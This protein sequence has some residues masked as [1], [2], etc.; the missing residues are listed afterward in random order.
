LKAWKLG[1]NLHAADIAPLMEAFKQAERDPRRPL[2][3]LRGRLMCQRKVEDYLKRSTKVKKLAPAKRNAKSVHPTPGDITFHYPDENE[4]STP[5]NS[6]KLQTAP[7]TVS[8]QSLATTYSGSSLQST[9]L[10][11][12]ASCNGTP[13]ERRSFM[14]FQGQIDPP[15]DNLQECCDR[16]DV[17]CRTEPR[18]SHPPQSYPPTEPLHLLEGSEASKMWSAINTNK[19]FNHVVNQLLGAES[20]AGSG[21]SELKM[22]NVI[23]GSPPAPPRLGSL[24][25]LLHDLGVLSATAEHTNNDYGEMDPPQ[26]FLSH[27]F[28]GCILQRRGFRGGAEELFRLA[29]HFLDGMI[30]NSH[31]ECLVALNVMLAVLET[32]G[33]KDDAADFLSGVLV[34]CRQNLSNNPVAQTV[35]FMVA[36]ATRDLDI[37][38][39]DI[40]RLESIYERLKAQFGDTSSSALAGLYHIAWR[41][42]KEETLHERALRTLEELLPLARRTLNPSHFLIITCMTTMAGVLFRVH[43]QPESIECMWQAIQE[44][45]KKHAP[46]HPY[47]LEALHRLGTFLLGAQRFQ[48]AESTLKFVVDERIRV[49]GEGNFLTQRSR[50]QLHIAT[51]STT[52]NTRPREET[53]WS[54]ITCMS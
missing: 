39:P 48:E 31:R 9:R 7:L 32:Q 3:K 33:Q 37:A 52:A 11:S 49:L 21:T 24:H 10:P 14:D 16:L 41:C 34:S 8:T 18:P 22:L 12:P 46:F 53:P 2:V 25:N 50:E 30:K 27:F 28:G 54:A 13:F 43:R 6:E 15:A 1:K 4:P 29:V 47:R 19:S 20:L 23:F 38:D 26:A 35:E 44:I 5:V 45:N 17:V 40:E 51:A 36:V 42:S